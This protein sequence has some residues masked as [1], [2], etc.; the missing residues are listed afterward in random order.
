[1]TRA[2]LPLLVLAACGDP[3]PF[4]LKFR[5]TSG[6]VQACTTTA[7]SRAMTCSDVTM[8]C[9][10]YVSIR[11][12]APSDPTAPFISACKPLVGAGKNLCSIASVDLTAPT[13]PTK[14]QDLEVDMAV[15]RKD[16]LHTGL[17]GNLDCPHEVAFGADGFPAPQEPCDPG[18]TMC[19][20]PPAIGGRAFYHPGDAET[21][22]SLGCTNQATLE[23][24]TCVGKSQLAVTSTVDDFDTGVSVSP[25]LADSL[26]VS[27]GEPAFDST[28]GGYTLKSADTR[29]LTL[30]QQPVPAWSGNVDLQLQSSACIEVFEDGAQT[31]AA[32]SCT[33]QIGGSPLDVPGVRLAKPTLDAILAALGK[34]QFPLEGLV[35]GL[36]LDYL[37]NPLPGVMIIPSSGSAHIKY[38]SADGSNFAATS[39]TTKGVWVSTDAPYGTTFQPFGMTMANDGF[40]GLVAGKVDVVIIQFKPPNTGG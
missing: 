2:L 18:A 38:M 6:D 29:A 1:M 30:M 27:I 13:M 4:T 39:T 11:I 5:V 36:A 24:P 37:G 26:L 25:A 19:D 28:L 34:T 8:L 17:D 33:D 3:P 16:Q 22:V 14:L 31:T 23:D 20:P 15:Y 12:F 40:G 9:D 21:V 35:V 10:A 7:G 32:L